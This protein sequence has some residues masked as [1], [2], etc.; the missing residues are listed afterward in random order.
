MARR[1]I[2][3]FSAIFAGIVALLCVLYFLFL[4]ADYVPLFEDMREDDAS[5]IVTELD[6]QG[7][8]YQLQNDGQD[9]L[10]A[11]A[12]VGTARLGLAGSGIAPG[13]IVGFE[14]FNESDMGLTEFAQKI[15]YQRALQGELARTIMMMEGVEF[16]RVH[17]ALPERSIFRNA[18]SQPTAAVTVQTIGRKELS[19]ARVSGIQQLV[20]SAVSDLPTGNVAVLDERG[21]LLSEGVGPEAIANG[22]PDERTALEQY[23]RARAQAV[24]AKLIPGLRVEIRVFA[25]ELPTAAITASGG[26]EPANTGSSAARN[27]QLRVVVRT[28]ASLNEEDSEGLRLSIGEALQLNP[29]AG[30]SLEFEVGALGMASN[31]VSPAAFDLA[32]ETGASSPASAPYSETAPLAWLD[33][34][35]SR[36]FLIIIF[37][38]AIVAWLLIRQRRQLSDE[39]R[40]SFA[41]LL[42]GNLTTQKAN[43]DAA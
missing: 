11:E 33:L 16:A 4:R 18:Q 36:W 24:A 10:V 27:F 7:I 3:L 2:F 35:F 5:A 8:A 26:S 14:L 37:V 29:D 30:D 17:L 43:K 32:G 20:A 15:N 28:A 6:K 40:A 23:F 19:P 41:E 34:I 21:G 42:N 12:D 25:R 38:I 9:I 1:Q 22:A 31:G 39:D 13:G